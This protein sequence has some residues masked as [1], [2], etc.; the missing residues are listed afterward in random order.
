MQDREVFSS[1]GSWCCEESHS[2][3]SEGT[4]GHCREHCCGAR[5]S[6]QSPCISVPICG[7]VL[8]GINSGGCFILVPGIPGASTESWCNDSEE[9]WSKA[10]FLQRKYNLS[11]PP[12]IL[13][14]KVLGHLSRLL[15][16]KRF[17]KCHL[18]IVLSVS[19]PYCSFL[20][21][22]K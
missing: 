8:Q 15:K 5:R 20:W 4:S 21:L 3:D 6:L 2:G 19:F 16:L 17:S 14:D 11:F 1:R 9:L 12:L 10:R 18:F 7:Y 13:N 22:R